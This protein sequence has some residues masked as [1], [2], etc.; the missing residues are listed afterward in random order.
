[1]TT[2]TARE[3]FF[4]AIN[5]SYDALVSA[6]EAAEARGHNVSQVVLQEARKGEREVVE[7][8]RK[9]TGAPTSF[10]DTFATVV[11]VQA[12]AERRA[13]ELARDALSG[14]NE[15]RAE[16]QEALERVI[17]A[18]RTAT[19]ATVDA[20]R[21]AFSRLRGAEEQAEPGRRRPTRLTN[22]PVAAKPDAAES[23]G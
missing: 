23:T 20:L 18:N 1:M 7:L 12:R 17:K 3:K 15:Y 19:E 13:L 22:V 16:V 21:N 2:D 8:A 11:E 4:D 9:W 5:E 14:A 10:F 6:V